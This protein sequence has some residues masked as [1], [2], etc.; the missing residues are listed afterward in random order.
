MSPSELYIGLMSGTSIDGLDAAL[1]NLSDDNVELIAFEYLPF[2]HEI[3]IELQKLSAPN[4]QIYLQ[5]YGEMDTR[6]ANWFV[7][8]VK[9]L[10]SKQQLSPTEIIAIGRGI[11]KI[12]LCNAGKVEQ[13]IWNPTWV[14]LQKILN[15]RKLIALSYQG[16]EREIGRFL[17]V[18]ARDKFLQDLR[19]QLRLV[20]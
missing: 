16:Q 12:E 4:A 11:L 2:S 19:S 15:D 20:T 9:T 14:Q 8:A 13:L 5:N 10:L 17:H 18:T 7:R 6:L 1:V 3:Q